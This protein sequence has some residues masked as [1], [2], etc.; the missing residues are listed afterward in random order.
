MKGTEGLGRVLSACESKNTWKDMQYTCCSCIRMGYACPAETVYDKWKLNSMSWPGSIICYSW[1][2]TSTH[3]T[4][5]T[6]LYA[7]G[8]TAYFLQ[9]LFK[10]CS[11]RFLPASTDRWLA[12]MCFVMDENGERMGNYWFL[13][14]LNRNNEFDVNFYSWYAVFS[15]RW[16]G[17]KAVWKRWLVSFYLFSLK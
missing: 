15:S 14:R 16:P 4:Q 7:Y 1:M 5:Y 8:M 2:G 9:G 17:I 10:R 12:Q 6:F 11:L 13:V 3:H